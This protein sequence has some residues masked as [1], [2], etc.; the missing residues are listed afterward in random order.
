MASG[1]RG[2]INLRMDNRQ[3]ALI[4]RAAESLGKTRTEFIIDATR[5]EAE[6]VLLNRTV[7]ALG[8]DAYEQFL[9][10]LSEPAEP[11]PAL[12]DLLAERTPWE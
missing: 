1:T 12:R 7:F 8:G 10:A 11:T 4:D 2:Q 3:R 9:D 6:E 5:R